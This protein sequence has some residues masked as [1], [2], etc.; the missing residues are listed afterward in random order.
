MIREWRK[1]RNNEIHDFL[2]LTKYYSDYNIK[3]D[4]MD[5]TCGAYDEEKCCRVLVRKRED[6]PLVIYRRKCEVSIERCVQER[7]WN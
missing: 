2:P 3:E 4:K 1:L 5:E 6:K 7:R